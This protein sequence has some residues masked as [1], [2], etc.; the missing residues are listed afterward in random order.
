MQF[1]LRF[2]LLLS[3]FVALICAAMFALPAFIAGALTFSLLGI[4]PTTLACGVYF[5]ST[6]VKAFCV[7]AL[8]PTLPNSLFCYFLTSPA[9]LVAEEINWWSPRGKPSS[10][11][12][13]FLY[14]YQS[15]EHNGYALLAMQVPI[16]IT[17]ILCGLCGLAAHRC[18]VTQSKIC[19]ED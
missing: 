3:T 11:G 10:A 12:D 1:S 14:L 9:I 17:A 13:A 19:S 18:F 6:S 15:W 5:G 8:I 2:L 16:W 7:G 4:I